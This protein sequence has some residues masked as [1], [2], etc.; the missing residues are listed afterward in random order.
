MDKHTNVLNECI[1]VGSDGFYQHF[2]DVH[3]IVQDIF[4]TFFF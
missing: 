4:I 1:F 2:S 3:Y